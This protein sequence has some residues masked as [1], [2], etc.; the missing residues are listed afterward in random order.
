MTDAEEDQI[1]DAAVE[2]AADP[3]GWVRFAYDW[4]H[5]TLADHPGP[6]AWQADIM[7]AIRVH[8]QNPETRFQPLRIAVASGHGIGKSAAI[9]MILNWAMSTCRDTRAVVTANTEHQLRTKTWP[10]VAKWCRLAINAHWWKVPA[11]SLYSSD[12]GAEKSWSADAASWSANNTEAF[13]GLH[14]LGKR[15]VLVYDEASAIDDPVWVVSDGALTDENTEI[16]WIAFGNPTQATGRF[17]E[18]FGKFRHLWVHKQIDSRTV[19]GTNKAY[20][21]ELV[22]TWGEDSDIVKVRVRGMFPDLSVAQFIGFGEVE[23]AQQ[24]TPEVDR[25][26]ALV[27]GVDIARFGLDQSVIRF[28]AGRDGQSIKPIKWRK[29]DTT[30][31]ANQ[32]ANAINT[33]KPQAVFV[34]GGGV[35][36]GVVDQLRSWGYRMVYEVQFGAS[37][38]D[39]R[40]YANKRAEM[41]G[42]AK[43]WLKIGSLDD[44][45]EL[46]DDLTGP[47]KMY[48]KQGQILLESKDQMSARGLPSPDDGDAFVLT[49]AQPVARLDVGG[50][51]HDSPRNTIAETSYP[52]FS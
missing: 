29:Q 1:A 47:E 10:E 24:R 7:E 48:T 22:K 15:I 36:G 39:S 49:F 5:G 52:M 4:G 6:R 32:V 34:D 17:R 27:L 35:G 30:Y 3:L 44:D 11:L 28:R 42:D 12:K 46:R 50:A 43:E 38:T 18:C 16:I 31:S 25:G 2:C 51:L 9:A 19:E 40:T 13:A 33:Y 20:L 21:D 37:A 45:A 8:L 23:Q 41:Y 26:A 14:N